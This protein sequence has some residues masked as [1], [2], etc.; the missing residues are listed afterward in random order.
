MT[1]ESVLY[2]VMDE[3]TKMSRDLAIEKY[4]DA[5]HAMRVRESAS[6]S[7][8]YLNSSLKQGTKNLKCITSQGSIL[9]SSFFAYE[10]ND[11]VRIFLSIILRNLF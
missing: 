2:T 1:H 3:L 5:S 11:D 7:V 9:T 4:G 6:A 8:D 10:V